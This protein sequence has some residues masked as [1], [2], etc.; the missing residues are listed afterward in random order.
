MIKIGLTGGPGAGKTEV[1]QILAGLGAAVIYADG[2]NREL[3][4]PDKPGY[5]AV[6]ATFGDDVLRDDKRIDRGRLA[7]RVFTDDVE[8]RKLEK[9][10]WPVMSAEFIRRFEA[11]EQNQVPVAVLEAAVLFEAGWESL[12]DEVWTVITPETVSVRRLVDGEGLEEG[13]VRARMAAQLPNEEKARRSRRIIRNDGDLAAL[14]AEVE[15][16]W[17]EVAGNGDSG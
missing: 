4:E 11:M 9:A 5:V 6:V 1:A 16:A 12:V 15:S 7:E 8:R 14:R 3:Y 17:D 10:V 2:V 13:S